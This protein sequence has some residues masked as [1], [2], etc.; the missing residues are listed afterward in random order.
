[1]HC[2]VCREQEVAQHFRQE[3]SVYIN[4]KKSTNAWGE[5]KEREKEEKGIRIQLEK[6]K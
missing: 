4:K 1:M 3:M 5:R 2:C 6:T